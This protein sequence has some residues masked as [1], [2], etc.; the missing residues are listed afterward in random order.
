ML[1][2]EYPTVEGKYQMTR[3][4]S[5]VLPGAFNRR[6][7]DGNLVIW[8][9]GFTIW[10]AVWGNDHNQSA[11]SRLGRIKADAAKQAFDIEE[12]QGTQP[13]RFSYRL[14]ETADDKRCPAF[15]GFAVGQ[16]GHVQ[17]AFYFDDEA[18]LVAAKEILRSLREEQVLH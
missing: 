18:D 4:W 15:Y 12:E 10:V 1:H 16:D 17:I 2:P 5:V 14:K 8:R 9:P 13:L 6:F 3:Q 7:E 11:P